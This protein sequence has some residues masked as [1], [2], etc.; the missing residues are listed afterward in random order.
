[1]IIID[2]S[3][4]RNRHIWDGHVPY[5]LTVSGLLNVA[6]VLFTSMYWFA[7]RIVIAAMPTAPGLQ[8]S[9]RVQQPFAFLR[10]CLRDRVAICMGGLPLPRP[11]VPATASLAK[12]AQ[13]G[14]PRRRYGRALHTNRWFEA[15]RRARSLSTARC[16]VAFPHFPQSSPPPPGTRPPPPPLPPTCVAALLLLFTSAQLP[17]PTH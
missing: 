3:T 8:H 10:P 13:G 2:S 5:H 12:L 6:N 15:A 7:T 16:T 17:R 1:M 11:P 9:P 4:L 14:G